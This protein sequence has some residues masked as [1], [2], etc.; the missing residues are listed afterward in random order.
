MEAITIEFQPDSEY[1]KSLPEQVRD[2]FNQT[3]LF[4]NIVED[5]KKF[6]KICSA[7]DVLTD[8]QDAIHQ[9]EQEKQIKIL[10]LYGFLQALFLEQDAIRY[11]AEAQDIEP[12]KCDQFVRELRND[13]VGHPMKRGND[14]SF[15]F[16]FG[17]T[18]EGF[19][20]RSHDGNSQDDSYKEIKFEFLIQEHQKSQKKRM[21]ELLNRMKKIENKH[22]EKYRCIKLRDIFHATVAYLFEKIYASCSNED[23]LGQAKLHLDMIENMI[24]EFGEKLGERGHTEVPLDEVR[25]VIAHLRA[26]LNDDQNDTIRLDV[27]IYTSYLEKQVNEFIKYA[28]EIDE[29]YQGCI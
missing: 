25:Q 21:E 8:A 29:R 23:K 20:L 9:F 6:N 13:A 2:L 3:S 5:N 14:A 11:I 17:V 27:K 24:N 22:R 16:I 7:L 15:H 1:E 28:K 4:N 10:H 18:Q 26:R 12:L 19:S